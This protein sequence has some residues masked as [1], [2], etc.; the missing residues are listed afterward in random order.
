M[1]AVRLGFV[2][3]GWFVKG[4]LSQVIAWALCQGF[5]SQ[6]FWKVL[7]LGMRQSPVSSSISTWK[8][9]KLT[10]SDSSRLSS[11]SQADTAARKGSQG[12]QPGVTV[13]LIHSCRQGRGGGL[14]CMHRSAATSK[15]AAVAAA[16]A[17]TGASEERKRREEREGGEKERNGGKKKGQGGRRRGAALL[18]LVGN[19]IEEADFCHVRGQVGGRGAPAL[20]Q[21]PHHPGRN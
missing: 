20:L 3:A 4:C 15:T 21:N 14:S 8:W 17:A 19:F 16:V 12:G 11:T 10:F 7:S 1:P 9:V 2:A 5:D 18:T 6:G 13:G